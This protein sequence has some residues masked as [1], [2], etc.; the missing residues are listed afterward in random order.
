MKTLLRTLILLCLIVWLGAELFFPVVA[1][2]TFATLTP[3][4]HTAGRI[5]GQ[6]L[7]LVHYE[8]LVAGVL[9][10][11]VIA[12]AGRV[13]LLWRKSLMVSV[14][15]VVLMLALTAVSQFGII[16]RMETYRIEAGGAVDAAALD[17]PARI[18]FNRL[19]KTSE[20]VEEAILLLGVALAGVLAAGSEE[21]SPRRTRS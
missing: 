1:A 13:G 11:L 20:H 4:T 12:L 21:C 5:V 17:D 15:L 18:A 2:I 8:G 7:R 3:D 9:L 14:T 6:C 19:H 16:P 10:L